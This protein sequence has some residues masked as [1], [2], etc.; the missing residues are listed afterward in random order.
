[1]R[2]REFLKGMVAVAAF[3]GG[4]VM[5]VKQAGAQATSLGPLLD[6]WTGP[7]GGVPRFDQ[8]KRLI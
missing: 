7:H 1:M 4:S 6:P 2:R 3:G 5:N 8:V